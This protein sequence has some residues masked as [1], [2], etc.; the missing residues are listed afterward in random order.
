MFNPN[1]PSR[2]TTV[3]I[4]A[5]NARWHGTLHSDG[6]VQ[7]FGRVDGDGIVAVDL[8][9]AAGAEVNASITATNLTVA[10]KVNG[11][12]TCSNRFEVL[13]SGEVH[14]EVISPAIIVHEGAQVV[15]MLGMSEQ[16]RV[17]LERNEEEN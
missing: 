6:A 10:G 15:G 8:L 1:A 11:A 3:S 2:N 9:V 7:V 4:V 14:G 5:P 12:I 16:S 13:S 17:E